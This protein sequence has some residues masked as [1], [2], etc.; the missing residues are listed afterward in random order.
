MALLGVPGTVCDPRAPERSREDALALLDLLLLVVPV[1]LLL[2]L[3]ALEHD[4]HGHAVDGR[5]RHA[6]DLVA[7]VAAA[8]LT[9]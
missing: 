2:A 7:A 3:H 8:A 6:R 4:I 9:Q 1:G 5:Q